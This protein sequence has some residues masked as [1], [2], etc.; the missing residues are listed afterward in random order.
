MFPKISEFDR[1]QKY[2]GWT[3]EDYENEGIEFVEPMTAKECVT[4]E[5]Q[6]SLFN[7][8]DYILEEK[9][10]GTR[11]VLHFT[12]NGTRCFS[13]R[14]SEKTG[15]L[16]EN[17]DSLPHLRDIKIPS[18]E[19]TIIDGELF[20]PNRP[21]KDV[22][23]TLNCSSDK[24]IERQKSLGVV[25]LHAFDII[26]YKG[27]LLVNMPLVRRKYY[28][29]KVVDEVGKYYKS[30][31]Y[32]SPIVFVHY[33]ECGKNSGYLTRVP[34]TVLSP[35]GESYHTLHSEV[36][37]HAG[38]FKREDTA[39]IS[40]SPKA[41]YELIVFSGG[42]G[43][44]LKPKQGKYTEG[45]RTAEF[46]KIKK[47]LTREAI[48]VGFTEPNRY[49]GG[50][51]PHPSKWDYWEDV[52]GNFYNLQNVR[53]DKEYYKEVL[54]L[55]ECG[56]IAPVTKHYAEG[57]VGNIMFGVIIT[58]EELKGVKKPYEVI[59]MQVYNKQKKKNVPCKVLIVGECSG[60]DE[61]QRRECTENKRK[62][63]GGVVEI[64]ANEIFRDSGKLRHPR[65][66]RFRFDKNP[67]ECT[68][69]NHLL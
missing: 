52:N 15:W 27:V 18:L 44:M 39:L 57:L 7:N 47:F 66:L 30:K 61:E 22:S 16:C 40:L 51:N 54:S 5:E 55:Y 35:K 63:F 28:L 42:E 60:F 67:F 58:D 24:A 49:Y 4:E 23:S 69:E 9:Y 29:Q 25:V 10:D 46:L 31:G 64:K 17:S 32:D 37:K 68:W 36:E 65:F 33:F 3:F 13:R 2:S 34:S 19:G 62:Y 43:V 50:K 8:N 11:A 56:E 45:K 59:E 53:G 26:R 12:H 14:V 48:V 20:I 21:F 1:S 41:Y 38:L 6:D